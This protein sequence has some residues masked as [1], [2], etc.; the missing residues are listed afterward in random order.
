MLTVEYPLQ[1][2][3]RHCFDG[4]PE[5][6][7]YADAWLPAAE[8]DAPRVFVPSPLTGNAPKQ[9][10]IDDL[11]RFWTH[12]VRFFLERRLGLH[13][14][15]DDEQL[16]E[17]EAFRLDYLQ[18]YQIAREIMTSLLAGE[19]AQ[20]VYHRFQAAGELPVGRSGH[21]LYQ[22]IFDGALALVRKVGPLLSAPVE[23]VEIK[24]DLHNCTLEGWLTSL[25]STG[26]ISYRPTSLKARDL[27]RL[28]IQHLVLSL[29]Q[30]AG[31]HP[32]SIHAATDRVICFKSV[33]DPAGKLESLL[34]DYLR[35]LRQPL[36]FYPGTSMAWAEAKTEAARMKNARN[37]WHSGYFDGEEQDPAYELALQGQDPLDDRFQEL[38]GLFVPV[39]DH[40]QEL[41]DPPLLLR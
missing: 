5:T 17:E 22:E 41:S 38:A 25:Y 31:V 11:C 9:I 16:P 15:L 19:E 6:A 1:P 27:L 33:E 12:P 14:S 32:V 35:G 24:L 20:P 2:F 10:E 30:P 40:M 13:L 4:T 28:W 23:P 29:Q 21:L 34:H 39:L 37:A 7:S 8:N 26:R 18:R 36:H 3:S